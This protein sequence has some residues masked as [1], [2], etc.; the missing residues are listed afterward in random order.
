MDVNDT[1]LEDQETLEAL[2]EEK[3]AVEQQLARE[4]LQ[5]EQEKQAMQQQHEEALRRQSAESFHPSQFLTEEER[6][7]ID[8]STLG[9]VTKVSVAVAERAER[10]L[11]QKLLEQAARSQEYFRAELLQATLNTP[12]SGLE[13]IASLANNKKFDSWLK[14]EEGAAANG[15]LQQLASAPVKDIPRLVKKA[16]SQI[17]KFRSEQDER[18]PSETPGSDSRYANYLNRDTSSRQGP[19][20]LSDEVMRQVKSLAASRN[21]A[22]RAKAHELLHRKA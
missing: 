14:S 22:D 18:K 9:I 4:K 2:R 20:A 1:M 16:A 6:Q 13:D 19:Q 21:P 3:L 5:W 11:E 8:E 7:L 10:A 12:G 15:T 17:Q